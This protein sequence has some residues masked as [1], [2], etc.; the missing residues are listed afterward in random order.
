MAAAT[1]AVIEDH[2]TS[3]C[4]HTD[5]LDTR[6]QELGANLTL[7]I[8]NLELQATDAHACLLATES[9]IHDLLTKAD[10]HSLQFATITTRIDGIDRRFDN[11][12]QRF[13]EAF[14]QL[15]CSSSANSGCG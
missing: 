4:N 8:N 12:D 5:S 1:R 6:I 9:Q 3:V 11:F 10:S 15:D 14:R 13:D 2:L 7:H